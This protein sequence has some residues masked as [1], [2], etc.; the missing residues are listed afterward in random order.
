M[1]EQTSDIEIEK[2]VK[3]GV[4]IMLSTAF[5]NEKEEV[6]NSRSNSRPQSPRANEVMNK[7]HTELLKPPN[8]RSLFSMKTIRK[9]FKCLVI[10]ICWV[11]SCGL[12]TFVCWG[13]TWQSLDS[14]AISVS[15]WV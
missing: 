10:A 5:N 15:I 9:S 8:S 4:G 14:S 3:N 7:L 2:R 11:I 6:V 12:M 1:I 13:P